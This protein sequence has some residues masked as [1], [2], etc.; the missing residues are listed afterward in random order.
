MQMV[1]LKPSAGTKASDPGLQGTGEQGSFL[2]TSAN[3][4]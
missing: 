2:G 3:S 4:F 1:T